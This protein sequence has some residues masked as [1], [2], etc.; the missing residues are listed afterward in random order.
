M[1]KVL[2]LVL[3]FTVLQSNAQIDF[4]QNVYKRTSDI[5]KQDFKFCK[6]EKKEDLRKCKLTQY[7]LFCIGAYKEALA[8]SDF[9]QSPQFSFLDSVD[10]YASASE[11]HAVSAKSFI[12]QQAKQSQ[13]ILFNENHHQPIHRVFVKHMLKELYEIGFRYL[14]VEALTNDSVINRDRKL[15]IA[16][17]LY[18]FEPQ[19]SNF[20]REAIGI[21]FTLVAYEANEKELQ[22]REY[23]QALHIKEKV[24]DKDKS[25]KLIVYCGFDHGCEVQYND[26]LNMMGAW[27]KKLTN[28]NP[29]TFDQVTMTEHSSPEYGSTSFSFFKEKESAIFIKDDRTYIPFDGS[30]GY[31]YYI[32]HPRTMYVHDRP[33]WLINNDTKE[34]YVDIQR[35]KAKFPIL[36][37]AYHD[38]EDPNSTMP[39]DVIELLSRENVKPLLLKAGKYKLIIRGAGGGQQL[40]EIN[41]N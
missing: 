36:I 20:I 31:D 3:F 26:S 38:N 25:A 7:E 27:L 41:L 28:I 5:I 24:F 14:A 18:L 17:G 13:V 34:Y 16:Q 23:Y 6:S 9:F 19:F 37:S 12:I 8:F 11:Y 4:K 29:V 40:L 1:K 33:G 30:E 15:T 21:G 39:A 22:N 32:Y 10:N 2:C 35:I